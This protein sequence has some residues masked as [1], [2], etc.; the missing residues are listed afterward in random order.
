M[1][2]CSARTPAR[3]SG[4][5]YEQWFGGDPLWNR[6]TITADMCPR[7]TPAFLDEARRTLGPT[8]FEIEFGLQWHD[9]E[10]SAFDSQIIEAAFDPELKPL[11]TV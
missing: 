10:M 3:K 1:P 6:V 4:W 2:W 9:D 5:F 11:W 7:I 8:R